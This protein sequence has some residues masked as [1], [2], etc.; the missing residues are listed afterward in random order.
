MPSVWY[1]D[2]WKTAFR[3]WEQESPHTITAAVG[4]V[5]KDQPCPPSCFLRGE[6]ILVQAYTRVSLPERVTWVSSHR[7][8]SEELCLL[9]KIC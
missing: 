4:I 7:D 1:P 8:I 2:N 3:S 5:V 9:F 6:N